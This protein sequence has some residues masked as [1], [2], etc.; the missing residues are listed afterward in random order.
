MKDY[1]RRV[2]A[3]DLVAYQVKVKESDLLILSTHNREKEALEALLEARMVLEA[4]IDLHPDFAT[5]LIPVEVKPQAPP[6]VR[7]MAQAALLSGV[8]PMAAVA[9]AIA[10]AV[11]ERLA[12][13]GEE[14]VVENGGDIYM[15][16]FKE[17]VVAL[18]AGDSPLSMK[19]GVRV[20]GGK[21]RG[22]C[23]SSG[24]IGHSLSLGKAHSVTVV[25]SDAP[26]ADAAATALANLVQGPSDIERTLKEASRIPG[27]LGAA[28]ICEDRLG[29]WGELDIVPLEDL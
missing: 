16:S 21:V 27:V 2:G 5:S 25:A 19:V 28:V 23:T 9:G 10:Q 4:Y 8:G 26:L 13:E 22:V 17:R 6:L 29:A 15:R 3:R 14:V 18:F 1:R 24:R 20:P 11:G 12:S 7:Q